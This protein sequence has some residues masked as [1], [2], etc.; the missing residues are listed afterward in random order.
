MSDPVA[1]AAAALSAAPSS[2][3]PTLLERAMET[4]HTLEAKVEHLIHPDAP[5]PD[6]DHTPEQRAAALAAMNAPGN[7]PVVAA[8]SVTEAATAEVPNVVAGGAEPASS[9]SDATAQTVSETVG[10]LPNAAATPPAGAATSAA[11]G[12][13]LLNASPVVDTPVIEAPAAA[14]PMPRVTAPLPRESHLMLLE[15]KLAAMHAKFKTGERVALDEFEQ[16]LGHIR[17][18]L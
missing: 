2:T 18:V 16:I 6:A 3:E 1:E 15:H 11:T 17:A 13:V 14:E 4:I 10:E 12:N 7:A 9:G 8:A 5:V